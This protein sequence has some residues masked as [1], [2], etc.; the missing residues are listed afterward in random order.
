MAIERD[1]VEKG[2]RRSQID[3]FL[4]EELERAGYGGMEL[5]RTPMGTEITLKAEKP[6][7]VIGKGGKN[8]RQL[9]DDLER[10]FEIEDLQIDVQEV[11]EPDLNARI[12]ADKLA[13]ALER[14][15]YFR[16][17]GR[18]TLSRI[19]ES[20]AMGAE[21]VFS[22][23]VT[24]AR[25]RVVKFKEGYVKHCGEPAEE[26]V[27][28]G[29]GT[30]VMKL[31]T[32]GIQVSIIPPG[33]ELPD[34]FEVYVDADTEGLVPEAEATEIEVEEAETTDAEGI[35]ELVEEAEEADEEEEAESV[36]E[37]E[38]DSE[39]TEPEPEQEPET[40]DEEE[41]EE[42]EEAEPDAEDED[43]PSSVDELNEMSYRELQK[44]AKEVGVKAN[45]KTEELIEELAD[46]FGL[47]GG[48]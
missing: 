5:A 38:E 18:T 15:W 21:I 7:M 13:N 4:A 20:G 16:D 41:A 2:M 33:S 28:R 37:E 14:G 43:T 46:E 25:S 1:F 24:G 10:E 26:V 45:L 29:Q 11:D 39:E 34:K 44:L 35:E 40:P 3:E 31:G 23:K 48:D 22:G 30:A 19:M 47:E 6:G 27:E 12:V 8:I 32:I 42:T 9:T 17:A 36:E